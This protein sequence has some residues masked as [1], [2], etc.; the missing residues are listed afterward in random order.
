[1]CLYSLARLLTADLAPIIRQ[2]I[3]EEATEDVG[4]TFLAIVKC[5]NFARKLRGE[6]RGR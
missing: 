1:M 3:P 5:V 2:N 6:R 4:K